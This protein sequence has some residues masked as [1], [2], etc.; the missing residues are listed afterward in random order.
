MCVW[1]NTGQSTSPPSIF[2][3]VF[4]YGARDGTQSLDMSVSVQS[5]SH[6]TAWSF[7]LAVLV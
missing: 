4:L 6:P 2:P 1:T 5:L 7:L 3:F